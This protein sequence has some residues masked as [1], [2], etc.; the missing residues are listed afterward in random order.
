MLPLFIVPWVAVI[1]FAMLAMGLYRAH[2]VDWWMAAMLALGALGITL[3]GPTASLAVG[4]VGAAL[5]LVGSGST[6]M[7]V[8]RESDADWEHTP[9]YHGFRP[10]AG[11]H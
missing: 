5:F 11:M 4:I 2:A 1:G 9:D 3:A 10:A 8:L 6:G 7:M